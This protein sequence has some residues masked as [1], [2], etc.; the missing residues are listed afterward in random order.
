[1]VRS[2]FDSMLLALR[3]FTKRRLLLWLLLWDGVRFA[4]V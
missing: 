3:C 1:M 2:N 4:V